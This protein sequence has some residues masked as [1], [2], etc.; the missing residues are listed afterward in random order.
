MRR[1]IRLSMSHVSGLDWI[2]KQ[3]KPVNETWWPRMASAVECAINK[4]GASCVRKSNR[5]VL[6][7][8][9]H[10]A[11]QPVPSQLSEMDRQIGAAL[12][13]FVM[14]SW[15]GITLPEGT[16]HSVLPPVMPLE[17]E[18]V[19]LESE[20]GVGPASRVKKRPPYRSQPDVEAGTID[21][22]IERYTRMETLMARREAAWKVSALIKTG[23]VNAIVLLMKLKD[24]GCR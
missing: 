6:Y 12:G 17:S 24:M 22:V 13:Q 1:K 19:S 20:F 8:E 10:F 7:W 4:F 16:F 18:L 23:E 3:S 2:L 9:I 21:Q 11:V 15:D 14:A 5:D